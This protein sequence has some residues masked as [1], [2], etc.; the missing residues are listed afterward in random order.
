[1]TVEKGGSADL[2]Y[3]LTVPFGCLSFN[4]RTL[5]CFIELNM[6]SP[7]YTTSDQC[8][9]DIVNLEHCRVKIWRDSWST[10]RKLAIKHRGRQMYGVFPEKISMKLKTSSADHPLWDTTKIPE[11]KVSTILKQ[12]RKANCI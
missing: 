3:N 7:D 5:P 12:L 6:L 11:I 1:M 4:N 8:Y 10:P 9:G 2:S